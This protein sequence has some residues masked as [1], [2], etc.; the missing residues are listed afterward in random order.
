MKEINIYKNFHDAC[1]NIKTNKKTNIYTTVN[2][3]DKEYI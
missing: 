1:E 2:V 3:I